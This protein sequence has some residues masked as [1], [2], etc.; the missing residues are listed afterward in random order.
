MKGMLLI[1]VVLVD[2]KRVAV[3]HSGRDLPVTSLHCFP[4][5]LLI[6]RRRTSIAF[7]YMVFNF[8]IRIVVQGKIKH[9]VYGI[10]V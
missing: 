3:D 7:R 9:R 4:A 2:L 10:G 6:Y 5:D 8:A 1:V